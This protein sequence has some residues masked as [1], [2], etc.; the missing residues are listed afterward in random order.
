MIPQGFH[1]AIVSYSNEQGVRLLNA[2]RASEPE[3]TLR[4]PAGESQVVPLEG[5]SGTEVI[6]LCV[7][8]AAPVREE[9]LRELWGPERDWPPLSGSTVLRIGPKV[10]QL[11]EPSRPLGM[12]RSRPDPEEN[13]ADRLLQL[14]KRLAQQFD[15]FEIV[16]FAHERP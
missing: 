12:P 6:C 9:E 13:V 4:F 5:P 7:R 15:Y 3:R 8:R 1:A 10:L 2:M 11:A 16:A 14:G